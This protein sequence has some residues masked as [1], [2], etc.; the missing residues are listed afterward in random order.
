MKSTNPFGEL[1]MTK[2]MAD[3][4]MP[5]VD[6]DGLMA[7][8]KKNLEALTTAN[9]LVVEGMQAIARRQTEIFRQMMEESTSAMKGMMSGGSKEDAAAKQADMAKDAFQR[10]VTNMRELAEMIAK[11]N[12]EAFDIINRRVSES[13][14]EIKS[15]VGKTGARR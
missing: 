2:M 10:A 8:Q 7:S 13:L 15:T 5:G 9:R 4:R 3:F 11:S 6:V 1:D 14:D 12:G